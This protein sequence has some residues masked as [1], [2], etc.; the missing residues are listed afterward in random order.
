VGPAF[1]GLQ[2]GQVFGI[3]LLTVAIIALVECFAP[4]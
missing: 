3:V 4:H 2:I 1:A